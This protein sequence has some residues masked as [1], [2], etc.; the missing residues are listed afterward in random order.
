MEMNVSGKYFLSPEQTQKIFPGEKENIIYWKNSKGKW[1]EE[2]DQTVGT[3]RT[4]TDL[5]RLQPLL[6]QIPETAGNT[7][8]V[9]EFIQ[10]M[11]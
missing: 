10:L 4:Q 8:G 3:I 2:K 5:C 11:E 6:K 7:Q 9:T 1:V